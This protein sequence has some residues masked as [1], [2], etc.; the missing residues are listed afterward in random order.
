[1]F[2]PLTINSGIF[3][4]VLI[5]IAISTVLFSA[6][7]AEETTGD[8][9]IRL[10]EP[11]EVTDEYEVFGS[12]VAQVGDVKKLS[13]I[14]ANADA[15]DDTEVFVRAKV[16]KVCQKKGCFFVAQDGDAIARITFVDYS[17]FVPTDS[18]G[19]DVTIVGTFGKK[20]LSEEKARHYAQ[21]AGTDPSDVSGPKTE[22]SIVATSVIIP[23]T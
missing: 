6:T 22:Y 2:T 17:F 7:L 5:A 16:A 23:K 13:E 14:V 4:K 18:G 8:R 10:S 9:V 1:M 19:K 12:R 15:H 20:L 3:M 11:V 21:D